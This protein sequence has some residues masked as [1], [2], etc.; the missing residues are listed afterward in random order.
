MLVSRDNGLRSSRGQSPSP[1]KS[2]PVRM[3]PPSPRELR[4]Q[5]VRV[6]TGTDH[7]EE[8]I[9]F[10]R[11]GSPAGTRTEGQSLQPAVHASTSPDHLGPEAHSDVGRAFDLPH[12]VVR[13][14]FVERLSPHH[15]RHPPGVF[16]QV[17]RRLA[18]GVRAADDIHLLID[19]RGRLGGGAA[20]E[21]PFPDQSLDLRDTQPAVGGARSE[22]DRAGA[23]LA[24]VGERDVKTVALAPN[25]GRVVHEGELGAE[26]PS[27]LV[28]ALRQP[29]TAD[30]ARK[31]QVV[32]YQRA[33]GRLATDA[34]VVDDQRPEALRGAIDRRR[35][36][37][38]P[39][40]DDDH[41]VHAPIGIDGCPSGTR[42]LQVGRV[43]EDG[44]VREDNEWKR[45]SVA[46]FRHQ[47][48]AI[49]RIGQ[50][51]RV[52]DRAAAE[53]LFQLVA[54]AGPRLTDDVDSVRRDP[55]RVGP[56]EQKGRDRLVEELVRRS[57]RPDHVVLDL[58]PRHR[59][60]DLIRG[61]AVAPAAP[62]DQQ[63]SLGM[64]VKV[65]HLAQ[66]LTPRRPLERLSCENQ[67]H[68]FSRFRKRPELHHRVLHRG[69]TE[70]AIAPCVPVD[71]LA[72]DIA[73]RTRVFVNSEK[74]R[75]G[76]SSKKSSAPAWIRQGHA[77]LARHSGSF[78][79]RRLCV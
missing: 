61:P 24:A 37:C 22:D 16:G 54:P 5:P 59:L 11:L 31:A 60:E 63:P 57:R 3:N 68:V 32:A 51:E 4:R 78:A 41:V 64:R 58:P 56:L 79:F 43:R 77:Y 44:A 69:D 52:W 75:L 12:Q 10:N 42:Q 29:T 70:H 6:G 21:D 38:R 35:E 17:Q 9:G 72:F 14:P 19:R 18:G 36:T 33:G 53:D 26:D 34:A 1:S 67:R 39:A 50:K 23:D 25:R 66:Q 47:C 27:L 49:G 46:R 76:H 62:L 15:E 45:L 55:S 48:A 13:H 74:N 8:L 65:A 2:A 40:A 71:Q 73:Q 28:G 30:A 20:V 7:Q